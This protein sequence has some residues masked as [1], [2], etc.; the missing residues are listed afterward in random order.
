MRGRL[1]S[2]RRLVSLTSRVAWQIGTKHYLSIASAVVLAVLAFLVM[3]SDSFETG[4]P[5]AARPAQ[6]ESDVTSA[7]RPRPPRAKVLFYIVE[8]RTQRDELASAVHA[9]RLAF[10]GAPPV[11]YIVYLLAGTPQEEAQTIARL[12]F[13]E[14]AA[15]QGGVEM[16]V[17]DVR[18][19]DD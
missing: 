10:D 9:D 15:Q 11:D 3:S 12:N 14:L 4:K 19:R 7:F 17:I 2:T 1:D 18:P 16:R 13:E 8:D 5:S 6:E